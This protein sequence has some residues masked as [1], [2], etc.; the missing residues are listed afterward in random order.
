MHAIV[1]QN[2]SRVYF[3]AKYLI[4]V[5]I[6]PFKSFIFARSQTS[7]K[8]VGVELHLFRIGEQKNYEVNIFIMY[9]YIVTRETTAQIPSLCG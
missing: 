1:L 7:K 5:H 2:A 4:F 8:E 9:L 3:V 6:R